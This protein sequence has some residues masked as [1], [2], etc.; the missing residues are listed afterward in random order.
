MSNDSIKFT[1]RDD[2]ELP[3]RTQPIRFAVAWRN[4]FTSNSW[5]VYV[6]KT[7]DAYISC[8]DNMKEHKV[9]LH[10]SGQQHI[11]F[12]KDSTARVLSTGDRFMIQ[13]REPQYTQRTLAPF[14]LLFPPWG[15][16]LNEEQRE[17]VKTV[18]DKNNI[19]I[20]ADDDKM[21]V[22]SFVKVKDSAPPLRVERSLPWA[23]LGELKLEPGKR[24][25]VIATYEPEDKWRETAEGALKEA[26]SRTDPSLLEGDEPMLCLMGY[27]ADNSP[28][29]LPL[30]VRCNPPTEAARI[31]IYS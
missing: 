6:E 15:L 27:T 21:T 30:S 17:K 11:S 1:I 20:Q 22:V 19:W 14:R 18:W 2:L 28:Y 9:S 25:V 31:R 4:G 16:R 3:L 24:L 5:G 23:A 13:W 8:R 10:V 26:A 12:H 7:G 29:M